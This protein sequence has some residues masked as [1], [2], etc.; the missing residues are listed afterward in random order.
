MFV[1]LDHGTG[2]ADV[3]FFEDAQNQ[4]GP[5]LFG[6]RLMLI[7]GRVHRAGDR[8]VSIQAQ[9]GWEQWRRKQ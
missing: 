2:C 7:Q 5:L 4:A 6:T 8:G 1:S 9:N 3:A